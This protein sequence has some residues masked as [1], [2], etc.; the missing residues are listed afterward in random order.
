MASAVAQSLSKDV[1]AVT[2][3]CIK[4]CKICAK[5]EATSDIG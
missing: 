2:P 4:I 5:H 3:E 1:A